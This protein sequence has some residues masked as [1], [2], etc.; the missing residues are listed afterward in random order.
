MVL[1]NKHVPVK[2]SLVGLGGEILKALAG[3]P[4]SVSSAWERVRDANKQAS[5]EQFALAASFLFSLGAVEFDGENLRTR[6]GTAGP[7][8]EAS[9]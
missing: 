7:G 3:H 5:F 6:A 1:P 4:R 8:G 9:Q 2:R